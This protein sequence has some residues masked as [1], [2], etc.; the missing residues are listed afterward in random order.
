ML[1]C[2]HRVDDGSKDGYA[3][4]SSLCGND[5]YAVAKIHKILYFSLA[6]HEIGHT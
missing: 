1:F 6:T 4:P 3:W 2:F 5:N